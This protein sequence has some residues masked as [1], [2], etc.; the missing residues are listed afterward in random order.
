MDH[1][2]TTVWLRFERRGNTLL[3]AG[4]SRKR[5]TKPGYAMRLNIKLPANAFEQMVDI[6]VNELHE[7]E[8]EVH[9]DD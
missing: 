5:P 4:H 1:I 7:I 3:C 8:V 6:E 9:E 2:T